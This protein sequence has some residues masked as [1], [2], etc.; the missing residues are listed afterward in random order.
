[1]CRGYDFRRTNTT[2]GRLYVISSANKANNLR[3][4]FI[5]KEVAKSTA[6]LYVIDREF[7]TFANFNEFSE[8]KKI[9]K[10]S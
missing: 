7:V 9:R 6:E 1:M 8:I 4:V 5:E 2:V 3:R 10:N